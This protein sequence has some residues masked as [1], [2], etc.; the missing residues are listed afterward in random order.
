MTPLELATWLHD[1][2]EEEAKKEG[3]DTQKSCK[4]LPF[5]ELPPKNRRVMII[6]ALKL[7]DRFSKERSLKLDLMNNDDCS[8]VLSMFTVGKIGFVNKIMYEMILYLDDSW[9]SKTNPKEMKKG[10]NAQRTYNESTLINFQS[11]ILQVCEKELQIDT[12]AL[13]R[14]YESLENER[15]NKHSPDS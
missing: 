5:D 14:H 15:R 8:T 13:K 11:S 6:V 10:Y 4:D 7:L 9:V 3:W 2:Y 12:D 1:T